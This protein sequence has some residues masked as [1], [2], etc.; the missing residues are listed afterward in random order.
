MVLQICADVSDRIIDGQMAALLDGDVD[1]NPQRSEVF[2]GGG[3]K[4]PFSGNICT[5]T[6]RYVSYF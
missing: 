6:H 4:M 3:G 5:S 1:P 2:I